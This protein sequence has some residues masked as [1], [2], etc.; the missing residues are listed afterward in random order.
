VKV[1]GRFAYAA[2]GI[3]KGSRKPRRE[4]L[5]GLMEHEIREIS[6]SEL[7][8]EAVVVRP[9]F[10]ERDA[11]NGQ[12]ECYAGFEGRLWRPMIPRLAAA[13]VD[14]GR[15]LSA[16]RLADLLR[17]PYPIGGNLET[18]TLDEVCKRDPFGVRAVHRPD[19]IADR[20]EENY[21][22]EVVWSDKA[23]AAERYRRAALDMI[24]VDGTAYAA[25]FEPCWRFAERGRREIGTNLTMHPYADVTGQA[26]RLDR[27]EELRELVGEAGA[28]LPTRGSIDRMDPRFLCRDDLSHHV[29]VVLDRVL[30]GKVAEMVPFMSD[31]ALS[32]WADLKRHVDRGPEYTANDRPLPRDLSMALAG[33]RLMR[34]EIET[35][36]LPNRFDGMRRDAVT[37]F[38]KLFWRVDFELERRRDPVLTEDAADEAAIGALAAGP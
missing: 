18:T 5:F 16:E 7:V 23:A 32:I 33:L 8:D 36:R 3:P 25:A 31:A 22:G 10:G 30:D 19:A 4:M 14:E 1:L 2:D 21:L 11:K 12:R 35:A 20:G 37:S 13:E 26:F 34:G 9:Y 24:L 27:L 29:N 17:E 15:P 6:R 28:R 38:N